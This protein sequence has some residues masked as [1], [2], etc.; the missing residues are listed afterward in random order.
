MATT[1]EEKQKIYEVRFELEPLAVARIPQSKLVQVCAELRRN[2]D[3]MERASEALNLEAVN[4]ERRAVFPGGV[5]ILAEVFEVLGLERMEVAEGAMREGLLYDMVGRLTAE[6]ARDRT[7]RAMQARYHVDVPQAERVERTALGFLEQVAAAWQLEDPFAEQLLAWAARLH[8]IG[9][10]V[11]H[12]KYHQH[13]A[14]LLENADMPGF[15]REEQRLLARLVGGHRRK[16]AAEGFDQLLP[17]W[18]RRAIFLIVLLRLAVLL[19]RGRSDAPLPALALQAR[20]RTLELRFPGRW[21]KDHALTAADLIQEIE[22]L[23]AAEIRLRV[24][25]S[26]KLPAA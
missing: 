16:L 21:I 6:D 1:D 24:Y 7:V 22:L 18:D 13:G 15:P 14:Y 3:S 11:A 5:A 10:D 4:A 25:S 2:L 9:L 19:H 26:V 8:E 23:R 20:G 17:P 12:S